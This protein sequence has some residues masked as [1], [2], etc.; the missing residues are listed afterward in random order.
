MPA[1]DCLAHRVVRWT[2]AVA[3]AAESKIGARHQCRGSVNNGP[4]VADLVQSG[5]PKAPFVRRCAQ[6]LCAMLDVPHTVGECER[7]SYVFPAY[8]VPAPL[9]THVPAHGRIR[10]EPTIE[11]RGKFPWVSGWPSCP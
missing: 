10:V 9:H 8:E 1:P 6:E 11:R 5:C 2:S 7:L 3:G 4:A